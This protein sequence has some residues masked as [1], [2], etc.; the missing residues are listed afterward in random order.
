MFLYIHFTF[1]SLCILNTKWIEWTHNW[2]VESVC[3]FDYFSS[4]RLIKFPL[5]LVF[6]KI[7]WIVRELHFW[8]NI[9]PT[10]YEDEIEH[11]PFSQKNIY[12]SIKSVLFLILYIS[13]LLHLYIFHAQYIQSSIQLLSLLFLLLTTCFSLKRPSSG[14]LSMP[15]LSHCIKCIKC[16][17]IYTLANLMFLD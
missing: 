3:H 17:L 6:G 8:W 7:L 1:C 4:Q 2:K 9:N 11:Y 13:I 5:N 14:V 15:K 12:I 16:S 10:L